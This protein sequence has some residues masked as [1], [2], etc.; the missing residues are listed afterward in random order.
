MRTISFRIEADKV[1]AL[2]AIA[3]N[4]DRDRSYLLNQAVEGYLREQRR[5]AA[6]VDEGIEAADKGE[7]VDD[8]ALDAIVARWNKPALECAEQ[9][10]A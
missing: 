8:E 5:F 10:E 2:D 6:M 7:L 9:V 1:E 4:L 3:K